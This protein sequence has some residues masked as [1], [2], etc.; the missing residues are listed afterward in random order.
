MSDRSSPVD[1]I[2]FLSQHC[3]PVHIADKRQRCFCNGKFFPNSAWNHAHKYRA[4]RKRPLAAALT[5][6]TLLVLYVL[7]TQSRSNAVPIAEPPHGST[8]TTLP[9]QPP[10]PGLCSV[11]KVTMLYGSHKFSQLEDALELHRRHSHRWGCG[12]ESLDRDLT[13]RKLY[14]KHYFLLMNML[15]ELSKPEQERQQWLL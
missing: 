6:A 3:G 12:Y 7:S 4:I 11:T 15:H 2:P 1:L 10:A 8:H 5:I 14:S 13:S 9:P